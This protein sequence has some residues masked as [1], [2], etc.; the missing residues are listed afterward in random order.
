MVIRWFLI[1]MKLKINKMTLEEIASLTQ[2][3][4]AAKNEIPISFKSKK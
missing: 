3:G 1:Y 2:K 4:K